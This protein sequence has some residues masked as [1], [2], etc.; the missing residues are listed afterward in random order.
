[1]F[2]IDTKNILGSE[3]YLLLFY[4]DKRLIRNTEQK[5]T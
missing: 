2:Y 1:M 5:K 3:Q 4:V